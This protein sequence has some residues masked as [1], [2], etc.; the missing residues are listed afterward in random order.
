MLKIINSHKP[1]NDDY[2][3]YNSL[4]NTVLNCFAGAKLEGGNLYAM[5]TDNS[6]E[7]AKKH[8]KYTIIK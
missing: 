3:Y 5:S 6:W 2:G 7:E 8:C 1:H 4:F